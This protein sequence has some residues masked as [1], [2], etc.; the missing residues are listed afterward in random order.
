[1]EQKELPELLVLNPDYRQ[2]I[3]A[4]HP[5]WQPILWEALAAM[6]TD[7]LEEIRKDELCLPVFSKRFAAFSLPLEKTRYLL[8]GESP[9]PRMDSANGYAF[10]DQ[11]VGN[12]WSARGL[13]KEVNKATSLRNW[14]KA[15]LIARGDLSLAD[16]SQE[17]IALVDK[18]PLVQTAE[19]LFAGMMKKGILLLNA[20][21]IYSDGKVPYHA[22]KWQPFMASLLNQLA[23]KKPDIALIVFGKIAKTLPKLN[24]PIGLLA[25][26]PYNISFMSNPSVLDFFKPLDLLKK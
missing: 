15:L 1:M 7:Y 16:L 13:S 2:L 21:L 19:A 10:W 4:C 8:L 11:S 20:S 23:I 12:L 17:R 9:Y 26:H 3:H 6:D 25:E 5:Q 24:L 18:G 22:K 14:I